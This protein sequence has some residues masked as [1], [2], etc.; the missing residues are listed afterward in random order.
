VGDGLAL[1]TGIGDGE[2]AGNSEGRGDG[3]GAGVGEGAG[4][5]PA[6]SKQATAKEV[7]RILPSS[8]CVRGSCRR[9]PATKRELSQR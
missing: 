5:T 9:E 1:D 4:V 7:A 8:R 3:K 2:A 6:R